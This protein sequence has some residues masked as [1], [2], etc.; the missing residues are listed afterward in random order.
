MKGVASFLKIDSQ[1]VRQLPP[2]LIS[3]YNNS[4]AGFPLGFGHANSYVR[5][6][7]ALIG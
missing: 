7:V 6:G 1:T 4:R 3:L 5:H 2:K